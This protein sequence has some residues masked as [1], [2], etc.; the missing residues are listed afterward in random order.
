MR[1]LVGEGPATSW[2]GPTSCVL[3]GNDNLM[4]MQPHRYCSAASDASSGRAQ[5]PA[6]PAG[7]TF[8]CSG[9]PKGYGQIGQKWW[10]WE[11]QVHPQVLQR[12]KIGNK[13]FDGA[14]SGGRLRLPGLRGG[15]SLG[16]ILEELGTGWK[17][18][19]PPVT[20]MRCGLPVCVVF[21]G[22]KCRAS[23]SS[24]RSS[25]ASSNQSRAYEWKGYH[26]VYSRAL[27]RPWYSCG[28]AKHVHSMPFP[29]R[30]NLQIS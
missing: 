4:I 9:L 30:S 20:G 23:A 25:R 2:S 10:T 17:D 12:E 22:R 26:F 8:Q 18:F 3:F 15:R 24:C 5:G 1:H 11:V 28:R 7:A 14:D 13:Q 21:R 6:R 16:F 27:R 29:Q 19:F